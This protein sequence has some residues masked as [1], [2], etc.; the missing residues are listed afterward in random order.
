M[1]PTKPNERVPDANELIENTHPLYLIVGDKSVS[2]CDHTT[3][4]RFQLWVVDKLTD[5]EI[6]NIREGIVSIDH[7][8]ER[9]GEKYPYLLNPCECGTYLPIEVDPNPMFSSSIG[10]L[11]ELKQLVRESTPVPD[12]FQELVDAMT[13]MAQHSINTH[14]ALEIR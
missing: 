10:L 9:A 1:V 5:G 2:P 4:R 12:G 11:A 13:N 6:D 8:D 14:A 7:W 3:F